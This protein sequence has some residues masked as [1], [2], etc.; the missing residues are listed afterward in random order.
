MPIVKIHVIFAVGTI[1]SINRRYMQSDVANGS[2]K[3]RNGEIGMLSRTT[4]ANN[5][6]EPETGA[7]SLAYSGG[8]MEIT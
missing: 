5:R 7:S 8:H 6:N 1:P 2:A 3:P 4:L